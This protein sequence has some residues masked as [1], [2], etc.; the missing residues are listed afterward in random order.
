MKSLQKLSRSLSDA[1][2]RA[3]DPEEYDFTNWNSRNVY[4]L[5]SNGLIVRLS[6]DD[7]ALQPARV[8]EGVD[9]LQRIVKGR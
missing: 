7:G 1:I 9:R 3:I 2:R 4:I 5:D 8:S 6:E